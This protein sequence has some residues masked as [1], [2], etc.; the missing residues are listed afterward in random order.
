[1]SSEL[2][3]V[4]AIIFRCVVGLRDFNINYISE[5]MVVFLN[6]KSSAT[7]ITF[8][9]FREESRNDLQNR[10]DRSK[11]NVSVDTFCAADESISSNVILKRK[12]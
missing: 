11:W 5:A 8:E 2:S 12:I 4:P 9:N 3:K 7:N 1:M 10:I 6:E